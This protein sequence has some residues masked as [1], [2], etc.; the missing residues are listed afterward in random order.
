M[1]LYKFFSYP[2]WEKKVCEVE[3]FEMEEKPKTYY[4]KYWTIKKI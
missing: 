3:K 4:C 2:F 1:K